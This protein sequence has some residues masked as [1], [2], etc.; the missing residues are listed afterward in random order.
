MACGTGACAVVVA[1]VLKGLVDRNVE[2]ELPGG[3]LEID[4][5]KDDAEVMMT[6]PVQTVF[7]GELD[8]PLA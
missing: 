5:R 2:V 8:W 3:A 4:W 7:K 1:A 6:G